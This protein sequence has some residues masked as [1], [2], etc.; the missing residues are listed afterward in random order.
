MK[1]IWKPVPVEPFDTLYSVSNLGRVRRNAGTPRCPNGR[2]L[3][4]RPGNTG[5]LRVE[6][7]YTREHQRGGGRRQGRLAKKFLVHRLVAAAFVSGESIVK[8][9]VNHIGGDKLDNRASHLEWASSSQNMRHAFDTGLVE[10]R[11]GEKH[12]NAK[13]TQSEADSIRERESNGE[14]VEALADEF[15]LHVATIRKVVNG[16]VYNL[17]T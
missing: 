7:C 11:F 12:W 1:E 14:A 16:S 9:Q 15:S 17:A 13:L 3:K 6:L 2:M 5:Y 8:C 4:L 10:K